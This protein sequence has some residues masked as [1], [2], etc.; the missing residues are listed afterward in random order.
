MISTLGTTS[1]AHVDLIALIT[2]GEEPLL[3]TQLTQAFLPNTW[4]KYVKEYSREFQL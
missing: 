2:S 4:K 3:I 1:A